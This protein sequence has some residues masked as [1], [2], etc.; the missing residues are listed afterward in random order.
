MKAFA[1]I[2]KHNRI[3]NVPAPSDICSTVPWTAMS[4]ARTI[5]PTIIRIVLNF[6]K[7]FSTITASGT[8]SNMKPTFKSTIRISPNVIII[9]PPV[10]FIVFLYYFTT[11]NFL[12][13]CFFYYTLFEAKNQCFWHLLGYYTS[14]V[15][16]FEIF[17]IY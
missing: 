17:K 13:L 11:D 14:I 12:I 6:H 1:A 5:S 9:F 16:Y 7:S 2:P 3:A 4:I 15:Y 10:F 8:N